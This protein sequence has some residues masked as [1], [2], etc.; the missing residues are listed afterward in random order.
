[1]AK[2]RLGGPRCHLTPRKRRRTAGS[3]NSSAP[4]GPPPPTPGAL[5]PRSANSAPLASPT[6]TSRPVALRISTSAARSV[7]RAKPPSASVRR[8]PRPAGLTRAPFCSSTT[9]SPTGT[10]PGT[11]STFRPAINSSSGATRSAPRP[12]STFA[13]SSRMAAFKPSASTPMASPSLTGSSTHVSS[14]SA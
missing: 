3:A 10:R 4:I 8:R 13:T 2:V 6:T 1:M 14:F 11:I 5:A 12:S 9:T 7:G